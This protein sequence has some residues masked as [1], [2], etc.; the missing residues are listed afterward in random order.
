MLMGG[1]WHCVLF[2]YNLTRKT[3]RIITKNIENERK[4]YFFAYVATQKSLTF[5]HFLTT[6]LFFNRRRRERTAQEVDRGTLKQGRSMMTFG[7]VPEPSVFDVSD[8]EEIA[9]S[10]KAGKHYNYENKNT[11]RK[12]TSYRAT[13]KPTYAFVLSRVQ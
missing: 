11:Q 13:E 1:A 12:L 2:M 9:P 4:T 7:G 5:N 3:C 6:S 8:P 10:V